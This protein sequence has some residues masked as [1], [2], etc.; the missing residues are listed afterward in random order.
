[1]T[2]SSGY[3]KAEAREM[4]A[5]CAYVEAGVQQPIPD[6]RAQW[7]LL[8][9]SPVIGPFENK[10]Q[11][12]Q[13]ASDRRF[14]IAL[15]G[16]VAQAGSIIE[17]MIAMM[18]KADGTLSVGQIDCPYKFAAD[19]EAGIHFGFSSGTL[20]LLTDPTSGILVQLPKNGVPAG[21]DIYVT[22]HSQGA[23][24]ATLLRS[25]FE[26]SG[27]V[28]A[29]CSI[30]TYV[31]AQPKPGNQH[32]ADDFEDRF[33]SSGMAF[34]VT[35]TLD[36]VPQVPFTLQFINDI[37]KPNPLSVVASPSL[38]IQLLAKT[39]SEVQSLVETHTRSRLQSTA[40][41]LAQAKAPQQTRAQALPAL[42]A[43][44]FTVPVM[45]TL[46]YANAGTDIPIEGAPCVGVQCQD[47][48][49]RTP[50]NDILPARL[51]MERG[52]ELRTAP[53][54]QRLLFCHADFGRRLTHD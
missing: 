16:T 14:A 6:P 11:L 19:P 48:I 7:A 8:F 18:I 40:V 46:N 23:A 31:F 29:N 24:M 9:D 33:C 38:L 20:L 17:D 26:H 45:E 49:I 32:Y 1:M 36:W 42:S 22:G 2:I 52:R 10:W 44:P 13:R 41:A 3:D 35:N 43:T 37:D 12:W 39:L 21:S 53:R 5:L 30:K 27:G 51:T 54:G 34:R 4:L 28:P 50:R 15:R 25:Y 47:L